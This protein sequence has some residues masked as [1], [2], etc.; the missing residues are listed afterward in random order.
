[1]I[2]GA[3]GVGKNTTTEEAKRDGK[4]WPR[5]AKTGRRQGTRKREEIAAEYREA[6]ID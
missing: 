4:G 2:Y 3:V 5:G 6:V 1:M